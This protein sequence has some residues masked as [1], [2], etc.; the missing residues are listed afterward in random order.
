MISLWFKVGGFL[1]SP[2][3]GFQMQ[4]LADA[5]TA[6]GGGW[7]WGLRLAAVF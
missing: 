7:V 4:S 5:P 6:A 1:G 3:Q 2:A